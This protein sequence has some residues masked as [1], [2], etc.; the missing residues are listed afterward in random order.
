MS[1][2]F[3]VD[4]HRLH[5]P[6]PYLNTF[7]R[8]P[9]RLGLLWTPAWQVG[10]RG[11]CCRGNGNSSSSCTAMRGWLIG[12]GGRTIREMQENSGAFLHVIREDHKIH[13]HFHCVS[14]ELIRDD[15]PPG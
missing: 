3:V 9:G 1:S 8:K 4:G 13:R 5:K 2:Q 6:L 7:P 10:G 15:D 14:L 12:K 11:G